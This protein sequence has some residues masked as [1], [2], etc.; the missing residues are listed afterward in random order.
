M[1]MHIVHHFRIENPKHGIS[2]E[3]PG[4][5]ENF[6]Y[7]ENPH[8]LLTC[9]KLLMPVLEVVGMMPIQMRN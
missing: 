3:H 9:F 1:M 5:E 2:H 7:Q 8:A 6:S 4:K